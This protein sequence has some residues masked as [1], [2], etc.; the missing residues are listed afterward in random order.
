MPSEKSDF[1]DPTLDFIP[2]LLSYLQSKLSKPAI[3]EQNRLADLG[4]SSID[5]IQLAAYILKI[6]N[7]WLDISKINQELT[8]ANIPLA[9]SEVQSPESNPKNM[10][11]LDQLQRHTYAAQINRTAINRVTYIIHYLRLKENVD[12]PKLVDAIIKTLDNH[13]ILNCKLIHLNGDLYLTSSL[14]QD[15]ILLKS[16]IFFRNKT[17]N[18]L[19]ITVYSDRL[20]NIFLQKEKGKYNLILNFHHII[21]DGWGHKLVQEEIFRRYAGLPV[22]NRN[23]IEEITALNNIYPAS[24]KEHSIT[25][26]LRS[27]FKTIDPRQYHNLLNLFDGKLE[28]NYSCLLVSKEEI[29]GYAIRNKIEAYP[30]STIFTFMIYQM[31]HQIAKRSKILLYMTLSNRFLPIPGIIDLVGNAATGLPLFLDSANLSFPEFGKHIDD[32]LQIYFKH[33]SYGAIVRVLLEGA[34]LLNKYLSP[35]E[36]PY[37][38]LLTYTKLVYDEDPIIGEYVD[39]NSSTSFFSYPNKKFFCDIHDLGTECI[40]R[41]HSKMVKNVHGSLV[42]SFLAKN[43]PKATAQKNIRD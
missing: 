36:L 22:K 25:D 34:T 19:I 39:C 11:K 9:L 30:Y 15:E 12:L 41:F 14:A 4:M 23:F 29:N 1:L 6:T 18:K 35:F 10:V 42:D 17:K 13:F 38:V 8:L 5:Y 21:L 7:K 43:F 31:F 20:V 16:S 3:N 2:N 32:I 28:C 24:M 27:L 37:H 33:M 26:E 40:L